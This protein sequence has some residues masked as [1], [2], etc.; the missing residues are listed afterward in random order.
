M[1]WLVEVKEQFLNIT[2]DIW[3][4]SG[5]NSWLRYCLEVHENQKTTMAK[6][7]CRCY[8]P[9][10]QFFSCLKTSFL[11]AQHTFSWGVT[12]TVRGALYHFAILWAFMLVRFMKTVWHSTILVSQQH[13]CQE[14]S[15]IFFCG[16]FHA[17]VAHFQI[18]FQWL[19]STRQDDG[20]VK[21]HLWPSWSLS[22]RT[23]TFELTL[24]LNELERISLKN[25]TIKSAYE[26]L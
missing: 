26:R 4:I 25:K 17:A 19:C 16:F 3:L 20:S 10:S 9:Q 14:L 21:S 8:S 11:S 13:H 6:T 7:A 22:E 2:T 23:W 24:P 12:V 1:P 15:F 5:I 18:F